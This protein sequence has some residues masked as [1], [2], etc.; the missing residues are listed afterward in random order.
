[1]QQAAQP[2]SEGK[3][4]ISLHFLFLCDCIFFQQLIGGRPI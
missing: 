4:R 1:M 3:G 2:P